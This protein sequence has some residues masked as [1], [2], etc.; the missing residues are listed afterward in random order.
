VQ[1]PIER[2]N[3][4]LFGKAGEGGSIEFVCPGLSIVLFGNVIVDLDPPVHAVCGDFLPWRGCA[5]PCGVAV[6]LC[7]ASAVA[8]RPLMGPR[9]LIF[10]I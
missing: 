2:S 4:V 7:C 6:G 5:E 1:W 3:T 10:L 8:S 9:L